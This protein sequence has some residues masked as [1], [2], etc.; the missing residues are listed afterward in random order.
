M[1]NAT[2]N[3]I[4]RCQK[5][6]AFSKTTGSKSEAHLGATFGVLVIS[7]ENLEGDGHPVSPPVS[8]ESIPNGSMH[9]IVDHIQTS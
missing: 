2:A 9:S 3:G 5:S 8:T 1:Y 6:I 7:G 4:P